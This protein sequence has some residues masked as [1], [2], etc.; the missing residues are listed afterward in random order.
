MIRGNACMDSTNTHGNNNNVLIVEDEQ[1]LALMLEDLL[2]DTGHRVA[3]AGTLDDAFALVEREHFDAA[4]LDINIQGK[5]VFP[6][7]S[8]LRELHTPFVFA[9]ANDAARIG[10]EFSDEQLIAKPYTI[11]QVQRS[12]A[13]M[14]APRA[15]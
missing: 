10:S 5:E 14:L 1:L 11:D 9:S 6:L 7:A 15:G 12:L 4:I 13:R 3:H 8:R 2:L